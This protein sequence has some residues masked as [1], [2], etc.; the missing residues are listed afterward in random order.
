MGGGRATLAIDTHDYAFF[1]TRGYKVD[2][3]AFEAQR[4]S[5]GL[6]KY[7]TA[8]ARLG[9]AWTIGD[10]ILVGT[11][12][13]G[14]STHGTLPIAD[15]Y[16][17]GGPR[18]LSGFAAGQIR[19]DDMAYGR[20]EV[21]YKLTKPI[22][23]LGLQMIAGVLAETGRMKD[24][25]TEPTLTGWQNSY[26]VYLAANSAFGPLYLGYSDAKNAKGRFYFFLG[27]P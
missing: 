22:P 19:G 9:G 25:V 15:L 21:Q 16:S 10:L 8:S 3:E 7:G 24:L 12:E 1:P 27:T 23:L 26:G 2:A 18:R 17:L 6:G 11:A 4:L 5:D 13:Y 20:F 14:R